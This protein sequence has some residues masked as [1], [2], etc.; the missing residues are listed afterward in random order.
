MP[1]SS[2]RGA[3]SSP[4]CSASSSEGLQPFYRNSRRGR[5]SAS[6]PSA[7]A[8]VV[9]AFDE[10]FWERVVGRRHVIHAPGRAI[11]PR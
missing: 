2:R 10:P 7:L 11:L 4:R 1:S 8:R 9:L 3:A 6:P 5:R